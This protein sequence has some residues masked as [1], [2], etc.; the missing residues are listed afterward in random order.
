MNI[1]TV[2]VSSNKYL[3]HPVI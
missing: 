1:R 2:V 3:Y